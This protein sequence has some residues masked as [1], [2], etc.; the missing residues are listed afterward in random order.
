MANVIVPKIFKELF[1]PNHTEEEK[2]KYDRFFVELEPL[3]NF[4][5]AE[6]YHQNYLG[7]NPWGYCHIT[8]TE[9]DAVKALNKKQ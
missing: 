2:K 4:Y 9:F 1:I 7:K 3:K 8:K 6:E 5:T